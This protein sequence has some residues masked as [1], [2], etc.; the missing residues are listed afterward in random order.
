MDYTFSIGWLLGGLAIVAAGGA[1][2]VFY[3]QISDNLVNGVSSYEKVK[4][5]GVVT[6]IVGLLM[7]SNL[8]PVV[9]NWIVRLLFRI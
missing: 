7:A 1:I 8:L 5:F 9:L 3:K 2:V 4:L 6:A